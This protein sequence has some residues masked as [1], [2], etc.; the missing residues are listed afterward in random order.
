MYKEYII[1]FFV[2]Y[3]VMAALPFTEN[4][5]FGNDEKLS[6]KSLN[7]IERFGTQQSNLSLSDS[8]VSELT[9][10]QLQNITRID[11]KKMNNTVAFRIYR[12][13]SNNM[14]HLYKSVQDR[15]NKFIVDTKNSKEI[16][17]RILNNKYFD[18]AE[19]SKFKKDLY[20]K[21]N[22][23]RMDELY[24]P[25]INYIDFLNTKSFPILFKH[26]LVEEKYRMTKEDKFLIAMMVR[27]F[28]DTDVT[29]KVSEFIFMYT[30]LRHN[31]HRTL[32][33]ELVNAMTKQN[34]RLLFQSSPIHMLPS[35]GKYFNLKYLSQMR[36][37][38][39]LVYLTYFY[40]KFIKQIIMF[41]KISFLRKNFE[42]KIANSAHLTFI[43]NWHDERTFFAAL[44]NVYFIH[45][46]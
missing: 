10:T 41:R 29:F 8:E 23:A 39:F 37:D 3:L 45:V 25:I 36:I 12:V 28:A 11:R 18:D 22:K 5:I 21:L 16:T 43:V 15:I 42:M 40:S 9:D 35:I 26:L 30:L 20:L 32:D 6:F 24:K 34:P 7:K 17:T 19:L 38:T 14:V 27:S 33:K 44:D 2:L 1:I 46:N 13:L 31:E 4:I